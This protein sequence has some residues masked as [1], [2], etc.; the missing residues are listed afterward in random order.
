MVDIASIGFQ[1]DTS[2]LKTVTDASDQL[3]GVGDQAK[4]TSADLDK[5]NTSVKATAA[6]LREGAAAAT[7]YAG[8]VGAIDAAAKRSG[9][10]IADMAARIASTNAGNNAAVSSFNTLTPAIT[11]TAAASKAASVEHAAHSAAA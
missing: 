4:Q 11:A 8:P 1:A 5:A 7:A 6:G 2:G 3:K 9:I 10:S